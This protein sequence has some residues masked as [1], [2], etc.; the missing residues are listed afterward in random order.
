MLLLTHSSVRFAVKTL[1]WA[2]IGHVLVGMWSFSALMPREPVSEDFNQYAQSLLGESMDPNLQRFNLVGRLFSWVAFPFLLFLVCFILATFGFRVFWD[3]LLRPM[4]LRC[5]KT[6]TFLQP[7]VNVEDHTGQPDFASALKD[8]KWVGPTSYSVAKM[9]DYSQ[10]FADHS[11]M[12]AQCD[13]KKAGT[14]I[15]RSDIRRMIFEKTIS[16]QKD[17]IKQRIGEVVADQ[18]TEIPR[19]LGHVEVELPELDRKYESD[20]SSSGAS[21]AGVLTRPSSSFGSPATS[22]QMAQV[23]Y[24][25]AAS[26]CVLGP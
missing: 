25:S 21:A 8:D 19:A 10:A 22:V 1:R 20:K 6:A 12:L 24:C 5:F 15:T 7:T 14:G 4:L 17:Y 26:F 18:T 3:K 13:N 11:E 23:L 9:E 16:L 2:V